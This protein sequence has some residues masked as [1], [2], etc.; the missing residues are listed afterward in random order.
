MA[1]HPLTDA[2]LSRSSTD[3]IFTAES[4]C[5]FSAVPEN[6]A[7]GWRLNVTPISEALGALTVRVDWQRSKDR[8]KTDDAT[9]TSVQVTLKQGQ[10]IP[11]DYIQAGSVSPGESCQAVGM[12]LRIGLKPEGAKR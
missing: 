8:T 3:E 6:P 10:S 4:L 7:Y 9:K 5:V 12:L 11:L 2:A 1:W